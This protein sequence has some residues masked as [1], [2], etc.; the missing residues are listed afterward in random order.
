MSDFSSTPN[1]EAQREEL[2]VLSEIY[3]EEIQV[4]S[5]EPGSI[6]FSIDIT[7]DWDLRKDELVSIWTPLPENTPVVDGLGG[8]LDE[9]EDPTTHSSPSS[10]STAPPARGTDSVETFV[11]MQLQGKKPRAP[12]GRPKIKRSKSGEHAIAVEVTVQHLPPLT[13]HIT[14]PET[15]PSDSPP[16]FYLECEWLTSEQLAKLCATLDERA[17]ELAGS[18][19]V[20]VWAECLKSETKFILG[21]GNTIELIPVGADDGFDI[22]ATATCT[23]S[24]QSTMRLVQHD[25][26]TKKKRWLSET[27]T[28][29]ICFSEKPGSLFV[30]LGN[31][32][33]SFCLDCMSGMTKMHVKESSIVELKCPTPDCRAE[34]STEMLEKVLDENEFSRWMQLKTQQ[35]LDTLEG[36]V[37]CPRCE[38]LGLDSPTFVEPATSEGEAPLA[39]CGHCGYVFCGRCYGIAHANLADCIS[40]EDRLLQVA[41]YK[42][43]NSTKMS[44]FAKK[45]ARK[46]REVGKLHEV[47][48]DYDRPPVETTGLLTQDW[49]DMREGDELVSIGSGTKDKFQ[50]IWTN[51]NLM[52]GLDKVLVHPLPLVYRIRRCTE[53]S[54]EGKIQKRKILEELQSLKALKQSSMPCPRCK[55]RISRSAGCNH[56]RC[57]HCDTHFCYRCGA[58]IPSDNPYSHFSANACPTFDKGEVQRM[59]VDAAMNADQML[60][61]LRNQFGRQEELFALF[62]ARVGEG[63]GI[64]LPQMPSMELPCR[65]RKPR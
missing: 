45:Q 41:Q 39:T 8:I 1:G 48:D 18:E 60:Q 2:E 51:S 61:D 34:F 53:M 5:S 4:G 13:M 28:C 29:F 27:H 56:M 38:V 14:F 3:K 46:E 42:A 62:N 11:Q 30:E 15:Y 52:M 12:P 26:V 50:V 40:E 23:D 31:C 65:T 36:V 43:E 6:W 16:E 7:V 9:N 24:L 21:L 19:V 17:A 44:T 57:V 35:I 64:A 10:S 37:F 20:F 63:R 47:T 22:R 25:V 49:R 55:V 54:E 33:H 58:Q 32:D 59:Q